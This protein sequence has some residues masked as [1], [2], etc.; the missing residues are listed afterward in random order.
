[1]NIC[2]QLEPPKQI[3][4]DGKDDRYVKIHRLERTLASLLSRNSGQGQFPKSTGRARR[5]RRRTHVPMPI[6]PQ[7]ESKPNSLL[8]KMENL[9]KNDPK[10]KDKLEKFLAKNKAANSMCH[11]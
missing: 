9:L 6:I 4:D 8:N 5:G 7:I 3:K 11:H 2:R 1:M 10:L